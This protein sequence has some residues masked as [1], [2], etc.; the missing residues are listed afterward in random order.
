VERRRGYGKSKARL[1]RT[2]CLTNSGYVES[3]S[4]RTNHERAVGRDINLSYGMDWFPYIFDPILPQREKK[5][6]P[7]WLYSLRKR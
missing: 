6:C 2:M 1:A 4:A 3:R 5:G 7:Q